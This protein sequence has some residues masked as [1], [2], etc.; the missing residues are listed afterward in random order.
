[1]VKRYAVLMLHV[2]YELMRLTSP[3]D[4]LED[5]LSFTVSE[6]ACT[7]CTLQMFDKLTVASKLTWT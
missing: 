3:E 2:V 4:S 7:C 1:M 6:H 5:L